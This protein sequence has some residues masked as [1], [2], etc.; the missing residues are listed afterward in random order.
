MEVETQQPR[1][2]AL[3][4]CSSVILTS[5]PRSTLAPADRVACSLTLASEIAEMIP[6][7]FLSSTVA[8]LKYLRDGLRDAVA[9]LA[10][11]PVMSD[12][13]EVGYLNPTTA[14]ASCYR[15]VKQCQIVVLIIGKRYGGVD[16]EGISVTHKEFRA[17]KEHEI[18]TITFV[19]SQVL[20]YKEV[21]EADPSAAMWDAFKGM[22]HPRE[23]FTLIDEITNSP[24]YNGLIPFTSVAQAQRILKT[25]IADFV[26]ERLNETIRPIRS[27]VQEVLAEIKTLRNQAVHAATPQVANTAAR[28][29]AAM[30]FL[31]D[32][33]NAEYRKLLEQIGGDLDSAIDIIVNAA[34]FDQVMKI[35][36][37]T[38]EEHNDRQEFEN[39]FR[40]PPS[41]EGGRQ[42]L[43][44]S[45]GGR[46]YYRF[47]SDRTLIV[48][49]GILH[50]Y[51]NCQRALRSRIEQT[52]LG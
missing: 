41:E 38:I 26:G 18:P 42:S 51:R 31:L 7:I 48:S 13:G 8:D 17:A 44:A 37:V 25:Q 24:T 39:E 29:L 50:Y 12:H 10:Y 21:F 20:N 32:D 3:L 2:A 52:R 19:E 45:I 4:T 49:D 33:R 34:E 30:R 47:M 15:S 9:D 23:T 36:G 28:Y 1:S 46:G 27:E 16:H 6:N 35:M 40:R 43:F 11:N 22:D 14:A 5:T